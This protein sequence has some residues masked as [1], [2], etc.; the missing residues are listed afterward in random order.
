M[1]ACTVTG[2]AYKIVNNNTLPVT[3]QRKPL[4][5]VINP[6][7]ELVVVDTVTLMTL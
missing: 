7:H 1:R 5:H 3:M 6:P 2:S 4:C